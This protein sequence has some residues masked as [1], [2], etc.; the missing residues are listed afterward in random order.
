MNLY[1]A[2][3]S[4]DSADNLLQTFLMDLDK[5]QERVKKEKKDQKTRQLK[6]QREKLADSL[7]DY[8]NA[9]SEYSFSKAEHDECKKAIID[10]LANSEKGL[11]EYFDKEIKEMFL[12]KEQ[13]KKEEKS[14]SLKFDYCFS[15]NDIINNFL[16]TL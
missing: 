15:D 1:Q 4:G 10:T 2:L 6:F 14:N 3:K 8:F 12:T 7:I 9:L 5:A 16:K 13:E 11:S